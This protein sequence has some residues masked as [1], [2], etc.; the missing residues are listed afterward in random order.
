MEEQS[1]LYMIEFDLP[2]VFTEEF[3]ALIPKQR[4]VIDQM[5]D[6]GILK[7]FSL[8]MDRSRFWTVMEAESEVQVHE[9]LLRFPLLDFL[10]RPAVCE[11]MFHN[12]TA[13]LQQFS[14]N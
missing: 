14:L 11:L 8:S 3:E 6:E 10:G 9:R 1:K 13:M 4:Y 7:S 2:P 12:H 5:M